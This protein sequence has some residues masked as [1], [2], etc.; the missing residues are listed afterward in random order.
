MKPSENKNVPNAI[1]K[2]LNPIPKKNGILGTPGTLGPLN[3][4]PSK[5]VIYTDFSKKRQRFSLRSPTQAI[6]PIEHLTS[7]CVTSL[8]L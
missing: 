1:L 7:S 3:T 8:S 5:N 4:G 6:D 2:T